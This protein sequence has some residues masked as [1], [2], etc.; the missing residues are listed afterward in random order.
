MKA[1]ILH[2]LSRG[3]ALTA[4]ALLGTACDSWTEVESV[5]LR[6]ADVSR[7][8]PE[9]YTKYLEN[10][11]AY[12]KTE[13]KDVY[14]WFDNS[15]K[16]SYS[17]AH[18]ITDLPDS[19]DVVSMMSPD[20]LATWEQEEMA[21]VRQEK[22]MRVIYTIDYDTYKAEYK[23]LVE[24]ATASEGAEPMSDDFIGFFTKSLEKALSL[25]GKY[26]YDGICVRYMGKLRQHMTTRELREYTA[27]ENVF[28][29]IIADWA[30]RNPSA[31]IAFE[32]NPQNVID[33]TFF[34]R[35]ERVL[36]SGQQATNQDMLTFIL[37]MAL[38]EG[39]P[40]NKIG[41]VV[42]ATDFADQNK[43]VGYLKDGRLAM[44]GLAAWAPQTYNGV[45]VSAVGVY[46]AN[47][48][49]YTSPVNYQNVRDIITSVNPTLK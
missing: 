35:C 23:A 20:N 40:A 10:L 28:M 34:E 29:K 5:K 49:Y 26:Q 15:V 11:R 13:H 4:L 25:V 32:G 3:L 37:S 46:N 6:E 24:K 7:D 21:S 30:T 47:T 45:T 8:N 18:H 12:R 22:G 2:K 39:V 36:L 1:N 14:V 41:M 38:T 44:Q 42:S 48:D 33:K 17:R 9:L 31:L 27:Q 19:V 16:D 43:V